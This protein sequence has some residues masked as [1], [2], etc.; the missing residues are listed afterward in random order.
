MGEIIIDVS[1]KRENIIFGSGR[2]S[3]NGFGPHMRV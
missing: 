1:Q 3:K 2:G